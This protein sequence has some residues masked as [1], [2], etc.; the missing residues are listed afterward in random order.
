MTVI[1]SHQPTLASVAPGNNTCP[2]LCCSICCCL[3]FSPDCMVSGQIVQMLIQNRELEVFRKQSESASSVRIHFFNL[4]L[5][6]FCNS[7]SFSQDFWSCLL[8]TESH[9]DDHECSH[10][11]AQRC[12][13]VTSSRRSGSVAEV[14]NKSPTRLSARHW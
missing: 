3:P 4:F 6:F 14:S 11:G 9:E 10:F 7:S 1:P 2:L 5:F 12:V 13:S 8:N